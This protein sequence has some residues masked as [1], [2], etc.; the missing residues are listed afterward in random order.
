MGISYNIGFSVFGGL[1]PVLSQASL[2]ASAFGPGLVLS[3]SGLVT[4]ATVLGAQLCH[5]RGLVRLAHVR[6]V[7]YFSSRLCGVIGD[8][9]KASR[10]PAKD[11]AGV[12]ESCG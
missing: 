4:A 7:P 6:E 1:A 12:E 8:A 5:S 3:L 2:D 10:E 11:G 9:Q